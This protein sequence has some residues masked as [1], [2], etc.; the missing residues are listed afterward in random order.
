MNLVQTNL[1]VLDDERIRLLR[2][3]FSSVGVSLDLFGDLRVNLAGR[4]STSKTLA[5]MDVLRKEKIPFG[6]IT[7]LSRRNIDQIE[8][9]VR[10]YEQAG[11]G[12]RL[13]PLFD[14]AYNGQLDSFNITT[15]EILEAYKKVVDLWLA[16]ERG[17]NAVPISGHI[18]AVIHHLA[19]GPKRYYNKALWNSAL[20]VNTNGDC[21][22]AGDPYAN[23]DWTLG[24]LFES[25]L[26]EVLSG[27]RWE[28]SVASADKRL[29]LN[30]TKC[31]FF[32]SCPGHCLVEEETNCREQSP[33]GIRICV[34]ERMLLEYI[35]ARLRQ[36]GLPDP[37]A[38]AGKST[39]RPSE[40]QAS[41][42]SLP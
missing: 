42:L 5:N 8:K 15:M 1:T 34:V 40:A 41:A 35:E 4:D 38:L 2:E 25:P 24:N 37:K 9:I 16:S 28:K 33:E 26:G 29:A 10:F 6:C 30:C 23:P 11:L 13:L 7:V 3:G 22:A 39:E 19:G 12:F 27:A 20:L 21:Y 31:R 18:D 17:F 32:G 36:L 14:A